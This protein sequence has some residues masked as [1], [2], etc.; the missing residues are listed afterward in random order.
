MDTGAPREIAEIK[1]P[2]EIAERDRREKIAEMNRREKSPR[3]K[4]PREMAEPTRCVQESAASAVT[5]MLRAVSRR[6]GLGPRGSLHAEDQVMVRSLLESLRHWAC[7]NVRY[8]G[9]S[10]IGHSFSPMPPDG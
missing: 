10:V 3:E 4:S 2:R 9:D 6:E 5:E 1:S 8:V 7:V